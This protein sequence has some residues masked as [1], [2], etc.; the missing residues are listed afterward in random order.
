MKTSRLYILSVVLLIIGLACIWSVWH[1]DA[2]LTTGIPAGVSAIRFCGA[3]EGTR[4]LIGFSLGVTGL[5]IYVVALV[6]TLMDEVG[7]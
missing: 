3:A 7:N 6:W 1:G 5:V 4:V 2:G